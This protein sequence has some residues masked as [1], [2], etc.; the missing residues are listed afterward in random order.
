MW[1]SWYH[2]IYNNWQGSMVPWIS[3]LS[4]A[5]RSE[6]P[7]HHS[8]VT[9]SFSSLLDIQSMP[10]LSCSNSFRC[11]QIVYLYSH[12]ASARFLAQNEALFYC[13]VTKI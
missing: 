12:R 10:V 9:L 6:S 2:Y 11:F 3:A 7:F 1:N 5:R 13:C 8:C 4:W